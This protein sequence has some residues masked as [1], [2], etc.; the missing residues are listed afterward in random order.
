MTVLKMLPADADRI[1]LD[2]HDKVGEVL[3]RRNYARDYDVQDHKNSE[4]IA[5][6]E[7]EAVVFHAKRVLYVNNVRRGD[8]QIDKVIAAVTK[9]TI[10]TARR[11]KREEELVRYERKLKELKGKAEKEGVEFPEWEI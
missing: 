1:Y 8:E 10:A 2:W 9:A 6:A 7:L 3:T 4:A 11:M 5:K